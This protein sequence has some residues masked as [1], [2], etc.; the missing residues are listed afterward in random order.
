LPTI[1][2]IALTVLLGALAY[3]LHLRYGLSLEAAIAGVGLVGVAAALR[4]FFPLGARGHCQVSN[5]YLTITR[6]DSGKY[7][8]V[9]FEANV[10]DTGT[11]L[12]ALL[13]VQTLFYRKD[14]VGAREI[15][16]SQG[17]IL[18]CGLEPGKS[19]F[20]EGSTH[21]A[22]DSALGK[23]ILAGTYPDFVLR[24]RFVFRRA[25][26]VTIRVNP[27]TPYPRGPSRLSTL[28]AEARLMTGL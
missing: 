17:Q 26:S 10:L 27:F 4:E 13:E 18:P 6:P 19:Y 3:W 8:V 14:G 2:L 5:P 16:A 22:S 21:F 24:A 15:Q 12:D 28:L 23:F 7:L 9:K 11:A 25:R 1:V 20:V